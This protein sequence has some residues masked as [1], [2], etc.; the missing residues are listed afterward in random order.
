MGKASAPIAE[1]RVQK[2]QEEFRYHRIVDY[3]QCE[4]TSLTERR[5]IIT[6]LGQSRRRKGESGIRKS[7]TLRG[8]STMI[9][10]GSIS[11]FGRRS[12]S[13]NDPSQVRYKCP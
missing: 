11:P 10:T 12:P 8:G 6:V 13:P 2:Q 4:D 1:E 3:V 5:F 9:S 7:E